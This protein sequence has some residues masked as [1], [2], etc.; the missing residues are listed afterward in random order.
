MVAQVLYQSSRAI[1]SA[2]VGESAS[3]SIVLRA[4]LRRVEKNRTISDSR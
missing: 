1:E 4:S 2:K 3:D